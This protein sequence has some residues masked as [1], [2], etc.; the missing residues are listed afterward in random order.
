M[1]DLDSGTPASCRQVLTFPFAR[2]H[3]SNPCRLEGGVPEVKSKFKNAGET[4][5]GARRRAG[6]SGTK[7]KV[8]FDPS[9]NTSV[10]DGD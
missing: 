5:Q 2:K 10:T 4:R 1:Q 7:G 3:N 6:A 8:N 9:E